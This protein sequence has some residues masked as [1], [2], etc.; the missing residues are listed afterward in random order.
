[1]TKT[2]DL[3]NREEN[4]IYIDAREFNKRS[5]YS[6]GDGFIEYFNEFKK[7]NKKFAKHFRKYDENNIV[8]NKN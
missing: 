5:G 2:L 6:R 3:D 4:V 7:S 1:M 8:T